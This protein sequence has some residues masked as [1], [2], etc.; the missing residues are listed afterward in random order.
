[1]D[2]FRQTHWQTR[3]LIYKIEES[4]Q[5]ATIVGDSI[6]APLNLDLVAHER[7]DDGVDTVE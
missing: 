7:E 6:I 5:L 1:M 4:I 2:R 3:E